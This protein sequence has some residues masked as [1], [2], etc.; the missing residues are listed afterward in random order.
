VLGSAPR[1]QW[2]ADQLVFVSNVPDPNGLAA[3]QEFVR[4]YNAIPIDGTRAGPLA[5][6]IYDVMS[7]LFEAL[8]RAERIDRGGVQAA[9]H[10]IDFS[11]LGAHYAFDPQGNLID[12]QTY[13]FEYDKDRNPRLIP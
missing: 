11:G 10:Q 7:L 3:A 4:N 12:P 5:L 1:D 8:D 9:L 13:V 2:P 6:Q